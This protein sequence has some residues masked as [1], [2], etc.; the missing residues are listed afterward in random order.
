[1]RRA[2]ETEPVIVGLPAVFAAVPELFLASSFFMLATGM[3]ATNLPLLLPKTLADGDSRAV[4]KFSRRDALAP[5]DL[6]GF[7]LQTGVL[8]AGHFD[9][10]AA[11]DNAAG[12]FAATGISGGCRLLRPAPYVAE[13][14]PKNRV[15]FQ[16]SRGKTAY[17][18]VVDLLRGQR[19]IDLPVLFL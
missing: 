7:K 19:P 16:A 9:R 18:A 17:P 10:A 2:G 14:A 12:G 1:M 5:F 13:L 4:G 3:A 6:N 15:G 8:A 11:R